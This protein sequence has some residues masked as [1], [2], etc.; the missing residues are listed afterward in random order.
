MLFAVVGDIHGNMP[1]FEAALNAIDEQGIQTV[2]CTGDLVAGFPWP[3]EVIARLKDRAI[4][5]V[6][7][8]SDRLVLRFHR[9][10]DTLK[11]R[12]TPADFR[13]LE[14]AHDRLQSGHLEFLRS[15]PV[16]RTVAY[17]GVPVCWFHGTFESAARALDEDAPLDRFRRQRESANAP[18][19]CCGR[20]HR[21]YVKRVD[22]A[23]F[24]NPGAAGF[25]PDDGAYATYAV[26]DTDVQPPTAT[27]HRAAYAFDDVQHALEAAGLERV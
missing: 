1:A 6:Q 8:D 5:C 25:P 12:C 19:L 23:L 24:V 18:I 14:W 2:L 20:T 17:E 27:L 16:H 22:D 9:K 13:A 10:R 11:E 21:P 15:L 26:V 4:P 3:N 7:G